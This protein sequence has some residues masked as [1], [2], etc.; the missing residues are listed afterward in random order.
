MR[1]RLLPHGAR[2]LVPL[3]VAAI[4]AAM[5]SGC[6]SLDRES[7]SLVIRK[8]SHSYQPPAPGAEAKARDPEPEGGEAGLGPGTEPRPGLPLVDLGPDLEAFRPFA[9]CYRHGTTHAAES[10]IAVGAAPIEYPL[11][12]GSNLGY[13]AVVGTIEEIGRFISLFIPKA[14]DPPEPPV[15]EREPSR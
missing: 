7:Y 14:K 13:L 12:L 15:K 9:Y 3:V 10:L 2:R 1:W 5:G 4:L 6:A 8:K 11:A